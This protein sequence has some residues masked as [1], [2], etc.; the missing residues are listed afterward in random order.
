MLPKKVKIKNQIL[1]DS[2]G[3]Y[4]FFDKKEKLLYIGKAT[5]L[6]KRVG[7]YFTKAHDSRIA[8]MVNQIRRIDYIETPTVIEALVFEANQIKTQKPKYNILERDDKSFLYLVITNEDF[9]RP[10]LMRGLEIERLGINPFGRQSGSPSLTRRVWERAGCARHSPA[11]AGVRAVFGPYTSGAAL[12]KSLDIIRKIIPWSDCFPGQKRAC[13]NVH[14][15]HCPGV[16]VGAIS[17]KDYQKI[18]KHLIWFF[19]GRKKYLIGQLKKDMRNASKKTEFEKAAKLRNQIF[20]LEHIQ[21]VAVISQNE[22]ESP[23]DKVGRLEAYDISNISGTSAVGSMVVFEAGKPAKNLYRKF[24]IKTVKGT[25]DVAMLEEVL[26]RRLRHAE[27]PLPEIFVIDG[28]EGQVNRITKVFQDNKI[29]VPIIGIAKGFDRK[30]DRLVFDETD[31]ELKGTVTRNQ[32]LFQQARDEAHRFAVKYHR[33]V[34][35]GAL[36]ANARATSVRSP[37]DAGQRRIKKVL[38]KIL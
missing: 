37:A 11:T 22:P 4:F 26:R 35:N 15:G 16:C 18:I 27:W 3:V 21:D 17:K 6:K 24:K 31:F 33:T 8:E 30:Q 28:G 5:S 34:R 1:P 25:N 9:P 12:R 13:F 36:S 19:E 23:P 38:V 2:P 7:S 29:K 10:I 32:E 14:L 20:A